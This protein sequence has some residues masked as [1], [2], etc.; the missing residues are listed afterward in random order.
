MNKNVVMDKKALRKSLLQARQSIA[1]EI[2]QA[3]SSQLCDHLRSSALF[4][5]AQTVLAYFSIRQEPDLS[6]LFP[7]S[8]TWGFPR[9]VGKRLTWHVWSPDGS[10]ALQAGAYGI[11]EPCPDSPILEPDQV[12]LMLV[13][14][15]A[16]DTGGYRLGYGGG[17]YDRLLASPV[18][19]E[20]ITI[21]IVFDS[22]YLSIVPEDAWDQPLTAVCTEKGLFFSEQRL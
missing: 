13:P 14:A 11:P 10:L 15:I 3:K 18:W 17:F 12:D 4:T 2:W 1:P 8:K 16:C 22:A 9:C 19:A 21:G 5:Q 20:K 7:A 6:L